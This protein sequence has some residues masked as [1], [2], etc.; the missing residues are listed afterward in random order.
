MKY[1][2]NL[3]SFSKTTNIFKAQELILEVSPAKVIWFYLSVFCTGLDKW[4]VL[5]SVK[6]EKIIVAG[7]VLFEKTKAL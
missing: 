1:E 7:V 4:I 5:D 3:F 6:P 2:T